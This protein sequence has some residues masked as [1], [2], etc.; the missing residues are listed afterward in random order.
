MNWI[1]A[2]KLYILTVFF[3]T[4]SCSDR[5]GNENIKGCWNYVSVSRN[6]SLLFAVNEEDELNLFPDSSFT[7][8][9]QSVHKQARGRW[10]F[11][12]SNLHLKYELPDTVRHFKL[13]LLSK[14]KMV[15]QEGSVVFSFRRVL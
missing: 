13:T 10:K 2:N 14:N 8:H 7:Y 5:K 12:N 1:N 9:I 3:L 15:M 6:D 11:E 4:T